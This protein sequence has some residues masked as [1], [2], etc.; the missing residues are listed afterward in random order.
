MISRSKADGRCLLKCYQTSLVTHLVCSFNVAAS[1]LTTG[2]ASVIDQ[3]SDEDLYIEIYR[4][5]GRA[6]S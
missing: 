6:F 5:I 1:L 2:E 3:L 4:Y